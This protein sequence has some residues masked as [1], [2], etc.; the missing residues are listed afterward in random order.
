MKKTCTPLKAIMLAAIASCA[1]P[2]IAAGISC[3]TTIQTEQKATAPADWTV[4]YGALPIALAQVTIFEGP[5]SEQAS[6]VYDTEKKMPK[7]LVLTWNLGPSKR[8]Y[9]LQCAYSS[10][11]A[12]ISR[13]L[14]DSVT[15][16][17][18]RLA[19]DSKFV[20]DQPVVNKAECGPADE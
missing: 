10:T 4:G 13:R 19:R 1:S 18:V 5:P 11:N 12:M 16:C 20:N 9:W 15:R 6:L 7:E 3:P 8:G 2:A 17:E 14:P